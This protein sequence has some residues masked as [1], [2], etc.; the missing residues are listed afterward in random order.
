M[1]LYNPF[2]LF[3]SGLRALGRFKELARNGCEFGGNTTGLV[4]L[5]ILGETELA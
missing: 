4:S 5:Q 3:S 1:P 2:T